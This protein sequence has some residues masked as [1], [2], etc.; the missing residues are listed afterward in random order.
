[1]YD[2]RHGQSTVSGSTISSSNASNL[3]YEFHAR[4]RTALLVRR[5][6]RLPDNNLVGTIPS[7]IGTLTGLT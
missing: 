1:M 6:I 7:S 5:E 4:V 2:Q 3:A